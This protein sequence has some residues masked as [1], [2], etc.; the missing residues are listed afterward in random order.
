MGNIFYSLL[1]E[2]WPYEYLKEKKAQQQIMAGNRS[3][4]SIELLSSSDPVVLVLRKGIEMC[5]KQNAS[6]RFSA[7]DVATYLNTK[8]HII[9]R[10]FN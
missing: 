4:L 10:G 2:Q 8:L 7:I 9:E 3:N 1:M 6:G 5:W